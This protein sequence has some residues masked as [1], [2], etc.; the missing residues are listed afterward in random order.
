MFPFARQ[1]SPGYYVHLKGYSPDLGTL[2]P[3]LPNA[4]RGRRFHAGDP[5]GLGDHGVARQHGGSCSASS[6]A[7]LS[8][9]FLEGG[10]GGLVTG[11]LVIRQHV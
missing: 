10:T 7:L 1:S 3:K 2:N 4:V 6:G 8:H 11:G 5:R 9:A